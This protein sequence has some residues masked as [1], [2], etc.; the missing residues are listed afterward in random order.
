[1]CPEGELG[2][3]IGASVTGPPSSRSVEFVGGVRYPGLSNSKSLMV[4]CKRQGP[5]PLPGSRLSRVLRS[6]NT[7]IRL[8][9]TLEVLQRA[10]AMV[11]VKPPQR[12][13]NSWYR[14]VV[15]SVPVDAGQSSCGTWTS[16]SP[17]PTASLSITTWARS[18]CS[19]RQQLY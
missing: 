15:H 2:T 5:R 1:M 3:T 7:A 14:R 6:P 18:Y 9:F 17:E 19:L 16:T 12:G 4:R 13:S 11:A 8:N 10:H